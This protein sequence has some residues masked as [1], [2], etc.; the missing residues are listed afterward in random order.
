MSLDRRMDKE[1]MVHIHNAIL[2]IKR[3]KLG[4]L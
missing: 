1:D 2:V 3:M 4:H